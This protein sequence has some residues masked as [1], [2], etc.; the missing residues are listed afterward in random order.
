MLINQSKNKVPDQ[1][2]TASGTYSPVEIE[3]MPVSEEFEA[4]C[5]HSKVLSEPVDYLYQEQPGAVAS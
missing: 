3:A 4:T 5:T 2:F 1:M